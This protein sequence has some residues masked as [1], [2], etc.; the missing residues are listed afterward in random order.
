MNVY[1]LSEVRAI[2]YPG[3]PLFLPGNVAAEVRGIREACG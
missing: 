3:K 2:F 1:I